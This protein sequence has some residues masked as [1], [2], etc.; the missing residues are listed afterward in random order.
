M[1]IILFIFL[2]IFIGLTNASGGKVCRCKYD[3]SQNFLKLFCE[4]CVEEIS[5]LYDSN[6]TDFRC[7]TYINRSAKDI[8]EPKTFQKFGVRVIHFNDCKMRTLPDHLKVYKS[9]LLKKWDYTI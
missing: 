7:E 6:K 9:F 2:L 1:K 8:K 3:E 4:K 5:G